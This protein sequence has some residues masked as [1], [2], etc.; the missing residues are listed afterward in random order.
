MNMAEEMQVSDVASEA[1]S[2]Q[3]S[4]AT[5]QGFDESK[6]KEIFD[7]TIGQDWNAPANG[8]TNSDPDAEE[9]AEDVED[10]QDAEVDPDPGTD[11]ELEKYRDAMRR[12]NWSDDE[13]G[14]LS[15]ERIREIGEK[16]LKQ[17]RDQEDDRQKLMD[18]IRER[19]EE[20]KALKAQ[21][22]T[23][24][25][26]PPISERVKGTLDEVLAPLASEYEGLDEVLGVALTKFAEAANEDS[27]QVLEVT[28]KAI[29]QFE[30]DLNALR[31][32]NKNLLTSI[33][34]LMLDQAARS[35][36][37][38]EEYGEIQKPDIY[39][40]VIDRAQQL[41]GGDDADVYTGDDG[42]ID[43]HKVTTDAA[44][45]VMGPKDTVKSAQAKI[46]T[47]AAA[48]A[49]SAPSSDSGERDRTLSTEERIRRVS[50][51]LNEGKTVDEARRLAG[52]SGG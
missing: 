1:G 47:K 40:K 28:S 21:E 35:P 49:K 15:E 48:I 3:T 8:K 51:A 7:R 38:I 30:D 36:A 34:S 4:E 12:A 11:P 32:E 33:G 45:L 44:R 5:P 19:E 41:I 43:W 2:S 10:T 6:V 22:K 26:L 52:L 14:R 20:I 13:I 25:G 9:E 50:K 42:R 27:N 29:V 39:K 16:R 18:L 23:P 31:E 17:I 37:L 24:D 46:A